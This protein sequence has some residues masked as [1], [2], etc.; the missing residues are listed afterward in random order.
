[1]R[2]ISIFKDM[3]RAEGVIEVLPHLPKEALE[4]VLRLVCESEPGISRA[5]A[6][7]AI[8]GWMPDRSEELISE[9]IHMCGD[10]RSDSWRVNHLATMAGN[11]AQMGFVRQAVRLVRECV[12]HSEDRIFP[13][14]WIAG[15][16]SAGTKAEELHWFLGETGRMLGESG[17]TEVVASIP[18][19]LSDDEALQRALEFVDGMRNSPVKTRLLLE[20]MPHMAEGQRA[21]RITSLL[22][23]IEGIAE[24]VEKAPLLG[25]VAPFLSGTLLD[26]AIRLGKEIDR[27]FIRWLFPLPKRLAELGCHEEAV[28]LI[29]T[30][31]DQVQALALAEIVPHY[32]GDRRLGILQDC[33]A[34]LAECDSRWDRWKVWN[35][36]EDPMREV[37]V[38]WLYLLWR[39]TLPKLAYRSREELLSDLARTVPLIDL[40][41]VRKAVKLAYEAI[42]QTC[43]WWT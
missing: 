33:L 28:Q 21:S 39:D 11:L 18:R 5:M 32:S 43:T 13:L 23:G 37:P 42:R 4:E 2:K 29:H 26:E 1:L 16:L 9:A 38:D 24:E 7:C 31:P 22:A 35:R 14:R 10:G 34:K 6:T 15:N 27:N 20:L 30:F 25:S 40:L 19:E 8:A 12:Q 3:E 17:W 36:L 41:G